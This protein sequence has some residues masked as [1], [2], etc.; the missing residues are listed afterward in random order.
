MII[1]K[2]YRKRQHL[3]MNKEIILREMARSHNKDPMEVVASDIE[4]QGV[5]G[6]G[7]FGIVKKGILKPFNKHVAVKMLKG[8]IFHS[9]LFNFEYLKIVFFFVQKM[10]ALTMLKDFYVKLL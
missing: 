5:L 4:I 10:Q 9:I 1:V 8:L 6:E 7:A 3:G 2:K